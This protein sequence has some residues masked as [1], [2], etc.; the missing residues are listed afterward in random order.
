MMSEKPNIIITPPTALTG[1]G[2]GAGDHDNDI[3]TNGKLSIPVRAH[4]FESAQCIWSRAAK[5]AKVQNCN[6]D[7]SKIYGEGSVKDRL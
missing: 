6:E 7:S 2:P 4:S 1:A 5:H 3:G